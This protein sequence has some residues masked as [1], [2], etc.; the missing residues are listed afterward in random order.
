M[1]IE[2]DENAHSSYPVDC[3]KIR[4]NNI[5]YALGLPCVF[6]RFNPDLKG[7]KMKVKETVLKSYIDFYMNKQNS[8]NEV[9]YLFYN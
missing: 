5:C 3:E 4:E 9:C 2:C 6:I 7:I 1:I 8:D